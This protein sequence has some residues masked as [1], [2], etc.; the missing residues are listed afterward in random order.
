M[1]SKI[2]KDCWSNEVIEEWPGLVKDKYSLKAWIV[3]HGRLA[4]TNEVI[5]EWA[6]LIK[7]RYAQ[8]LVWVLLAKM[9]SSL[10]PN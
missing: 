5:E 9:N 3:L 7:D 1:S 8:T 10:K 2:D 6:G 4:W